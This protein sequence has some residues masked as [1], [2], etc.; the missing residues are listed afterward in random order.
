MFNT[1][2]LLYL[3]VLATRMVEWRVKRDKEL[4][5]PGYYE[6]LIKSE[7]SHWLDQLTGFYM[8]I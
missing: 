1:W 4:T 7:V 6:K 3:N 2:S 8:D 5:G